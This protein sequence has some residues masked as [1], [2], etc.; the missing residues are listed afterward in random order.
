MNE[1][2]AAPRPAVTELRISAFRALCGARLPLAPFTLLTGPSG[3]G[4]STVLE[5]YTALARLAAGD[6]VHEVFEAL[7]GGPAACVPLAS[8]PDDTG[9]RGFRLGCTVTG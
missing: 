9:R 3:S 8:R 5:A 1:T 2:G 7:P 6:T 4:K